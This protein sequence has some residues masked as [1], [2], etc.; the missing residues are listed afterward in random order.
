LQPL[1]H[2]TDK[3]RL[4]FDQDHFA[5]PLSLR[6][7]YVLSQP[8]KL[9]ATADDVAITPLTASEALLEIV[10]HTFQLDVTDRRRLGQAF[11]QYEWL[12]RSVPLFR[13]DFPREH[14]FLPSVQTAI[15]DH[16]DLIHDPHY[17]H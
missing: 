2:Y 15:L 12:A 9:P 6:A 3:K 4:L 14:S 7:I 8:E 17:S 5:G 16:F 11:R 10:K 13:L 1:A